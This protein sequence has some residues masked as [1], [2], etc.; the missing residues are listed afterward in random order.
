MTEKSSFTFFHPLRVRW[1]ECDVQNIVYFANYF[2]FFDVAQTEYFRGLAL[3]VNTPGDKT[4]VLEFFVVHA[5]A[6]YSQPACYDDEVMVGVR[7]LR[8]GTTTVTLEFAV[9]RDEAVLV[10]GRTINVLADPVTKTPRTIP[11]LVID[12]ISA[13]EN[14]PPAR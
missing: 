6:D 8:F 11:A 2:T 9:C 5:E 12:R 4:D 14:T 3:N 1:G 13:F 7:A 10:A